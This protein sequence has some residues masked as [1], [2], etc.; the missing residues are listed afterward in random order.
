M[1]TPAAAAR[2]LFSRW[3]GAPH[4]FRAIYR[5]NLW[6]DGESRSGPG[7]RR[8]SA[9]VRDTLDALGIA[10]RITG[11]RSLADLPCGD[12]NWI[13]DYLRCHPGID[14]VGYDIVPELVA[15]NRAR[16]PWRFEVL[17]VIRTSPA[18]A[19]LI[20][21]KDLFNHL[22]NAEVRSALANMVASGSAWLLASNNFGARPRDLPRL[23]ITAT[24]RALDLTAPPFDLPAPRWRTHYL[25]LW[26]LPEIGVA[27]TRSSG[28]SP[29]R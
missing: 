18:R 12:C 8:D 23:D 15:A 27:L 6:K 3:R 28:R 20:L 26:S 14:Y 7:S 9:C 22:T 13:G 21:S 16:L 24:T 17:D 10:R 19:D 11:F 4:R 1:I 5:D 2:Y 25:A 29:S